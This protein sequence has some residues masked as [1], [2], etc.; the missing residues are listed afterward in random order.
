MAKLLD[1][2]HALL[3]E[4][5][6]VDVDEQAYA[7][8][9]IALV[10]DRHKKPHQFDPVIVEDNLSRE[11]LRLTLDDNRQ[12][13]TLTYLATLA[14]KQPAQAASFVFA[15]GKAQPPLMLPAMQQL[16][17]QAG[18]TWPASVAV[19]AVRAIDHALRQDD[20]HR[21]YLTLTHT[22]RQI[23]QNWSH[24]NDGILAGTSAKLLVQLT[25]E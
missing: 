2:W 9:R 6:S 20:A 1:A 22:L 7:S 16:I 15:L 13:D 25:D 4:A 23:L 18:Q 21:Q 12:R 5:A 3:R 11:L 8:F 19:E 17:E 14:S 10:L 24:S